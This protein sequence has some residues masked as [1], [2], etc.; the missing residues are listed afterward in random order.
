MSPG[1]IWIGRAGHPPLAPPRIIFSRKDTPGN[2]CSSFYTS[3]RW[4]A[5]PKVV[6]RALHGQ[7]LPS[8]QKKNWCRLKEG[9]VPGCSSAHTE[10]AARAGLWLP[11]PGGSILTA[12][13]IIPYMPAQMG[14]VIHQGRPGRWCKFHSLNRSALTVC[15]ALQKCSQASGSEIWRAG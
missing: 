3:T 10:L 11:L 5:V 1:P 2:S 8:L 14:A 13:N 9:S 4:P 7:I 12:T 6:P 15:L